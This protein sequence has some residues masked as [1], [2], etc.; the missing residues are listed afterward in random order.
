MFGTMFDSLIQGYI[1]YFKELYL[2]NC[3]FFNFPFYK[4]DRRMDF[5]SCKIKKSKECNAM[6]NL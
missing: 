1:P 2:R 4:R 3:N 5:F 6:S